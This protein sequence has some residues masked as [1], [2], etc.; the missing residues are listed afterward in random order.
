MAISTNNLFDTSWSW[1]SQWPWT[2]TAHRSAA[3]SRLLCAG[4]K[5]RLGGSPDRSRRWSGPV[6]T[7]FD[8]KEPNVVAE[9]IWWLL[10]TMLCCYAIM[11]TP[12]CSY[13]YLL[14]DSTFGVVL[15][16]NT[17]TYFDHQQQRRIALGLWQKRSATLRLCTSKLQYVLFSSGNVAKP[18][19]KPSSYGFISM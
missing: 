9:K 1:T 5:A 8:E 13:Q 16:Q 12:I 17:L 2:P 6:T 18:L 10:N 11:R 4:L 14:L 7:V 3:L 19:Q 15:A